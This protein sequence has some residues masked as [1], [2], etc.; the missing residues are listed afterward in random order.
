MIKKTKKI[1]TVNL[2]KGDRLVTMLNYLCSKINFAKSNI[3]AESV[4]CMNTLF[5][6][7]EKDTRIIKPA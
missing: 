5:L 1:Y 7:L 6:E 3:D 4:T 2:E